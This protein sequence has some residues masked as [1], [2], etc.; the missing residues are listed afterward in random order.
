MLFTFNSNV[1]PQR[2]E[3]RKCLKVVKKYARLKPKSIKLNTSRVI[4][5][6]RVIMQSRLG[7]S[8]PA[9]MGVSLLSDSEKPMDISS[10]STDNLKA[11]AASFMSVAASLTSEALPLEETRKDGVFFTRKR[12]I[13]M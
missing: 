9:R 10:S 6:I 3:G 4:M 7:T 5:I 13:E 1:G 8:A 11:C 2:C 12:R